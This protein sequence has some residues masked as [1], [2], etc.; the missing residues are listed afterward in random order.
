M[1]YRKNR[2]LCCKLESQTERLA[3]KFDIKTESEFIEHCINK[4]ARF[5][6]SEE[7]CAD[8]KHLKEW[9]ITERVKIDKSPKEK[10]E[11]SEMVTLQKEMQKMMY[12]Q[13]KEQRN[14][15]EH[16]KE[17]EKHEGSSLKLPKL[18]M[19]PFTGKKKN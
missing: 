18:D 15:L 9:L 6:S 12:S 3:E 11:F 19:L 4:K 5:N 14:F 1:Y 17:K 7:C 8:L 10:I 2:N 16:Q 13:L